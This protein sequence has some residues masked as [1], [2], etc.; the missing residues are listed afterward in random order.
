MSQHLSLSHHTHASFSLSGGEDKI[1]LRAPSVHRNF[2]GRRSVESPWMVSDSK[3]IEGTLSYEDI[4]YI[5]GAARACCE[6]VVRKLVVEFK[7]LKS[8]EDNEV[9]VALFKSDDDVEAM[10]TTISDGNWQSL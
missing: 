7:C 6:I 4:K 10:V 5:S 8:G 2:I 1:V 9:V 3:T